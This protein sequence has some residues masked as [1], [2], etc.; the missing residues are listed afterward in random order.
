MTLSSS[1]HIACSTPR[2]KFQRG[3]Q[4]KKDGKGESQAH[5][6]ADD[7]HHSHLA[8]TIIVPPQPAI[9]ATLVPVV[10]MMVPFEAKVNNVDWL[11]GQR[12]FYKP[13]NHSSAQAFTGKG[14]K[15][16][17][18]P[19]VA[20]AHN[21]A[22]RMGV[23]P[24]TPNIKALEA[25]ARHRGLVES[26]APY[27]N[28][29]ASLSC[30]KEVP[31][32]IVRASQREASLD[33]QLTEQKIK[34]IKKPLQ[35]HI[36][37]NFH[38]NMKVRKGKKKAILPSV[39][40]E[41]DELLDWG[42]PSEEGEPSQ[43]D[44]DTAIAQ[45][46]QEGPHHYDV[47]DAITQM[48]GI[49]LDND[50]EDFD[51]NVDAHMDHIDA[52]YVSFYSL[53]DISQAKNHTQQLCTQQLDSHSIHNFVS[54]AS[55]IDEHVVNCAKCKKNKEDNKCE[56]LEDSGASDTFTNNCNDFIEY[57]EIVGQEVTMASTNIKIKGVGAIFVIGKVK[58][59]EVITQLHPVYYIPNLTMRLLSIGTLL[60]QGYSVVGKKSKML[61]KTSSGKTAMI[62]LLHEPGQTLFWL[63]VQICTAAPL[64]AKHIVYNISYDLV[65][66]RFGHPSKDIFRHAA[67]QTKD[68]PSGITFPKENP[69][70][71]GCAEG[72]M[73][74]Q[75]YPL[76][77]T[78]A[79]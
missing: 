29:V 67:K 44:I 54:A 79:Q 31:T 2:K 3:S 12:I 16:T 5:A 71:N 77:E 20:L 7:Q 48:A 58:G 55:S 37:R 42:T 53:T 15:Q 49:P 30:I 72:K 28:A 19:E 62:L 17:S 73:P 6:S 24:N 8:S 40:S 4:G 56:W 33:H 60:A 32:S 21:L 69:I 26:S 35:E 10:H 45:V 68:F 39:V 34:E 25:L 59:K 64:M 14:K 75:S 57:K 11:K 9:Q 22:E 47:D 50:Y 74:L 43:A 78:H 38:Q 18:Y 61:F 65:H 46:C 66:K 1:R 51:P 27:A 36:D 41:G 13:L 23:T 70:C 76:S 63:D 52:E